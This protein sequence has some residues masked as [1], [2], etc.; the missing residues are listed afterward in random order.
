MSNKSMNNIKCFLGFHKWVVAQTPSENNNF[1]SVKY[2]SHCFKSIT[3]NTTNDQP[4][5][6]NN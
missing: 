1:C 6:K 2:C 5:V 4:R 3:K